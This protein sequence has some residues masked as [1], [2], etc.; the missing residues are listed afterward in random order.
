MV[1]YYAKD[2]PSGMSRA[3][4]RRK[5]EAREKRRAKKGTSNSKTATVKPENEEK[6]YTPLNPGQKSF[7]EMA[8]KVV[9]DLKTAGVPL[10]KPNFYQKWDRF[11][12]GYLP[13]AYTPLQDEYLDTRQ[14]AGTLKVL[15]PANEEYYGL[16]L[17]RN[18]NKSVYE[19]QLDLINKSWYE[20][21][22]LFQDAQEK[23]I[24][25]LQRAQ[26][27]NQEGL[28][29]LPNT[30]KATER[31]ETY[32]KETPGAQQILDNAQPSFLSNLAKPLLI[33]GA[34]I[35]GIM[36]IKRR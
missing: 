24:Q 13:G 23:Q 34:V 17:D 21:F 18:R 36:L 6:L 14:N 19:Q 12:G 32:I 9:K 2:Y 15:N 3:E 27:F 28:I 5:L 25:N 20:Q 8:D 35:L 11:F 1:V 22:G 29:Q 16:N 33:G 4:R 31:F 30:I 10:D 26:A 7:L